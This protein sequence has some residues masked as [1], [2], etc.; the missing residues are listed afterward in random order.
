MLKIV[1]D[2]SPATISCICI[3]LYRR[4]IVTG[5]SA[6][7]AHLY[8][9]AIRS[10]LVAVPWTR[11]HAR[12]VRGPEVPVHPSDSCLELEGGL[13]SSSHA[14]SC[15]PPSCR[16]RFFSFLEFTLISG[17]GFLHDFLIRGRMSICFLKMYPFASISVKLKFNK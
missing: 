13:K 10:H 1:F 15:L 9:N 17:F 2:E 5:T 12:K 3:C 6:L 16:S 11:V 7:S 8:N 14:G 4:Y